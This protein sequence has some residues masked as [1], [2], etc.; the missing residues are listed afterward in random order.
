MRWQSS[1]AFEGFRFCKVL[2][3]AACFAFFI[4]SEAFAQST[5]PNRPIRLVIGY[6]PGGTVKP[7]NPRCRKSVSLMT[8][9][10]IADGNY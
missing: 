8:C 10:P 6:G 9:A 2:L 4:T 7:R 1:A 3:A 5:Y